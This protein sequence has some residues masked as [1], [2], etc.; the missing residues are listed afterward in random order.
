MSLKHFSFY[1]QNDLT[2]DIASFKGQGTTLEEAWK[3][4]LTGITRKFNGDSSGGGWLLPLNVRLAD[5]R[6]VSRMKADFE[7]DEPYKEP[8]K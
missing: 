3:D 2:R 7:G 1:V 6:N 5:G 4:A 8:R